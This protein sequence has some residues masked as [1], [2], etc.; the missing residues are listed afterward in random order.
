M[1]RGCRWGLEKLFKGRRGLVGLCL[2]GFLL[3]LAAGPA[4]ATINSMTMGGLWLWVLGL[5][6]WPGKGAAS[7]QSAEWR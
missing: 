2:R 3:P 4:G 6:S 1:G 7:L 5:L